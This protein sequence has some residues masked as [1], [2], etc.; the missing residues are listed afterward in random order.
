MAEI[1]LNVEI[2]LQVQGT[3]DLKVPDLEAKIQL[4]LDADQDY[5]RA[6]IAYF[7]K[8]Y[9]DKMTKV[10]Q[11]QLK[12]FKQP[13]DSMQADLDGWKSAYDRLTN[14]KD[15][16]ECQEQMKVNKSMYDSYLK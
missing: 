11:E 6:K 2:T 13:L 10:F 12:H 5:E 7:Q 14:S 15:I 8:H 1:T 3:K 9:K 4:K 16:F